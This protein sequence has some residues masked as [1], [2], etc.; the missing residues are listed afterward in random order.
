MSFRPSSTFWIC[1][2]CGLW[3]ILL[4]GQTKSNT[5]DSLFQLGRYSDAAE[6]YQTLDTPKSQMQLAKCYQLL[7][8]QNRALVTLQKLWT[9]EPENISIGVELAK[10]YT[11]LNQKD[12]ALAMY[13]KLILTDS[14]NPFLY[15][16]AGLL[17]KEKTGYQTALDYFEK[18][19]ALDSFF[20]KAYYQKAMVFTL[21]RRYDEAKEW[22]DKALNIDSTQIE[23]INLKAQILFNNRDFEE[24]IPEYHKLIAAGIEDVFVYGD[25]AES[26]HRTHHLDSAET[27]YQKA[28]LLDPEDSNLHYRLS[29][30]YFDGEKFSEAEGSM[31]RVIKIKD[32]KLYAEYTFLGEIYKAQKELKK[33]LD[34]Y[35][36]AHEENPDDP[37]IY[38]QVC[39][40]ANNYFKDPKT[41]LNFYEAFL[42]KYG[43]ETYYQDYIEKRMAA[44]RAEIHMAKE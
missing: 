26:Y 41:Q 5:A 7:G 21:F 16:Q 44:L 23:L 32:L 19:I 18:T 30:V 9:R 3:P 35:Q 14:L 24:A 42:G 36:T 12:T 27:H 20:L 37:N 6:L 31:K 8:L 33:A 10:Y 1:I 39:I 17:H 28:L 15:Y 22:V 29:T 13:K 34:A 43:K 11:V 25:L 2:V 4:A 38:F 40:L